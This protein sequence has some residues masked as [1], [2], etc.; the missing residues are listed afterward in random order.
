MI[1]S[2]W[3]FSSPPTMAAPLCQQARWE[4]RKYQHPSDRRV[5]KLRHAELFYACQVVSIGILSGFLSTFSNYSQA[6]L[7][8]QWFLVWTLFLLGNCSVWSR[9]SEYFVLLYSWGGILILR[10]NHSH[11]VGKGICFYWLNQYGTELFD[12]FRNVPLFLLIQILGVLSL[13]FQCEGTQVWQVH[14]VFLFFY[15]GYFEFIFYPY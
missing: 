15:V 8:I 1:V 14:T 5:A 4:L 13:C 11:T 10:W 9:L 7:S 6:S 12:R 2:C 3:L